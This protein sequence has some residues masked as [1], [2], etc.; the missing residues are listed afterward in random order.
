MVS[1]HRVIASAS[2][3]QKNSAI[4]I[5]K[6][7]MLDAQ[8]AVYGDIGNNMVMQAE[9]EARVKYERLNKAKN[10]YLQQKVKGEWLKGGDVNTTCFH[11]CLKKRW[12]HNHI[13]KVKDINGNWVE[14]P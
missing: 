6:M 7:S 1:R 4:T 5:A 12:A 8:E 14:K 3:C 11:A 9:K 10:S 2:S 13:H